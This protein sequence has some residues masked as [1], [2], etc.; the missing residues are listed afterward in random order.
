MDLAPSYAIEWPMRATH[1][2]G[3]AQPSSREDVV[4]VP[5]ES[6]LGSNLVTEPEWGQR[7]PTSAVPRSVPL[8]VEEKRPEGAKRKG[9]KG[10]QSVP[11]I[12]KESSHSKRRGLSNIDTP[13]VTPGVKRV[14]VEAHVVSTTTRTMSTSIDVDTKGEVRGVGVAILTASASAVSSLARRCL[15]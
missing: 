10:P 11:R 15:L 13:L 12:L 7:T 4:G 5:A 8:D 14:K 6:G 3:A 2:G 9:S 1:A